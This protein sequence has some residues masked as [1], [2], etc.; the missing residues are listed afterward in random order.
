M[1]TRS[2]PSRHL[3][4]IRIALITGVGT[5]A[6]IVAW[7]RA[8]GSMLAQRVG[9]ELPMDGLRIALWAL[10]GAAVMSALWLRTRIA[11]SRGSATSPASMTI[12]GWSFGEGVALFGIMQ[13][14]LGAPLTTMA[15]GLLAFVV[16]LITLPVPR[17]AV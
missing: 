14:Y 15:V 8:N 6:A 2:T 3:L 7:Q 1:M 10:A 5:F 11:G 4:I 9:T 12:I 17:V 13:H 16:V